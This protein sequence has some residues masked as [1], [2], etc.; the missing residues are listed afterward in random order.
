MARHSGRH[1]E[2]ITSIRVSLIGRIDPPAAVFTDS[3]HIVCYP[4]RCSDSSSIPV[5]FTAGD[6]RRRQS[7]VV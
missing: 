6:L 2:E 1:A 4:E 5:I 7:L 3:S